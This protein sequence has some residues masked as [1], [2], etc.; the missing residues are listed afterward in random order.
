VTRVN[1]T[2]LPDYEPE[3]L[4]LEITGGSGN[5]DDAEVHIAIFSAGSLV[6]QGWFKADDLRQAI[7]RAT[8]PIFTR[9]TPYPVSERNLEDS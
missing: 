3:P 2:T 9:T 6:D 1:A 7:L 8:N 5:T 4:E